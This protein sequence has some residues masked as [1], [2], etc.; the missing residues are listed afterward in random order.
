MFWA[1]FLLRALVIVIGHTYKI[2]LAQDHF[3]FGWEMGRIARALVT[4]YGYADPF[5]GHTGPTAWT[6]PI[7]PLLLAGVFKLFGVYT[8]LSAWVI[9][10]INSVFSAAVSLF[11]YEIAARCYNLRVA[12]WSAWMWA[13]YPAALQYA[14]HWVWEMSLTAMLFTWVLALALRMRGI[15]ED[16]PREATATQW[17]GFGLLWGSIALSNST[18]LLFLPICG[19]WILFGAKQPLA[20][21]GKVA[22][23]S[24]VFLAILGSWETRNFQAFHKF[25]PIRGNMGAEMW[26]GSGPDSNGFAWMATLPLE[27]RNPETIRYRTLGE[28]EYTRQQGEKWHVYMRTHHLHY[29][30]ISLKRF[31]FFWAGVP[32]PTDAHPA[33]EAIREIDYC[34]FSI[35]GILGLLLSLRNRIPAAGLFAWS[36]VLLPLT[37]YFVT[38][39]ARF[40]HPLEPLLFLFTVYLFQSAQ[41]RRKHE[42]T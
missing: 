25:I 27:E 2:R 18:V 32:H 33:A 20:Q 28:V 12:K 37:Y 3:Q 16:K 19:L 30:A 22:L 41:P 36:F 35:T 11:V 4:G 34:F 29:A 15:G 5:V 21:L 40:R 39:A 14:I 13:V 7:F 31:Y 42:A 9:L 24:L 17:L 6:P 8:A 10:T 1:G 23:A 26:A 38:V